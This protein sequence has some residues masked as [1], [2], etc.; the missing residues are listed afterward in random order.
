MS[1][2]LFNL[3]HSD[4]EIVTHVEEYSYY[5]R[6]IKEVKKLERKTKTR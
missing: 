3:E 2:T 5:Q 6:N 4:S 1:I